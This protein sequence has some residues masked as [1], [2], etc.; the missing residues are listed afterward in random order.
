MIVFIVARPVTEIS[1]GSIILAFRYNKKTLLIIF[2]N[3]VWILLS[4][5]S[6]DYVWADDFS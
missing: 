4:A 2:F 5:A 1:S 6:L 3:V